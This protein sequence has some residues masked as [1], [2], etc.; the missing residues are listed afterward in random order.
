M[1]TE[2]CHKFYDNVFKLIV[3]EVCSYYLDDEVVLADIKR[4]CKSINR[5]DLNFWE[6]N[7]ANVQGFFLSNNIRSKNWS[8]VVDPSDALIAAWNE[9]LSDFR[10]AAVNFIKE[11]FLSMYDGFV[12]DGWLEEFLL[13]EP[14]GSVY[15]LISTDSPTYSTGLRGYQEFSA[16]G[17]FERL[18][19]RIK[20]SIV[21]RESALVRLD[22]YLRRSRIV[23]YIW[24][25]I[26]AG[27]EPCIKKYTWDSGLCGYGTVS[28]QGMY[29][30]S[31]ESI[32]SRDH[33]VHTLLIGWIVARLNALGALY[34]C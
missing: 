18:R 29:S 23:R 1:Y 19:E 25:A 26:M 21:D 15:S 28:V 17:G 32:D 6:F 14:V 4:V 31:M 16:G 11:D 34:D 30:Q 5:D 24:R 13:S 9:F 33:G 10:V 12:S 8:V 7:C 2:Y 22:G 3:E 27:F 20:N